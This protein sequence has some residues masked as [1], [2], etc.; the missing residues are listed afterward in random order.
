MPNVFS[1]IT[2][3]TRG[4][5]IALLIVAL[6]LLGTWGMPMHKVRSSKHAG[7]QDGAHRWCQVIS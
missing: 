5:A 4:G 2:V 7:R 6:I 3:D 1:M